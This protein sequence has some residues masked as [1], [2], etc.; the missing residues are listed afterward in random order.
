[1]VQCTF[2]STSGNSLLFSQSSADIVASTENRVFCCCSLKCLNQYIDSLSLV[3]SVCH[4]LRTRPL[5]STPD[6]ITFGQSHNNSQWDS[7][8]ATIGKRDVL[9]L[10]H[11]GGAQPSQKTLPASSSSSEQLSHTQAAPLF[12][13]THQTHHWTVWDVNSPRAIAVLPTGDAAVIGPVRAASA[14]LTLLGPVLHHFPLV[15][16]MVEAVVHRL[17]QQEQ[18]SNDTTVD[19]HDHHGRLQG[20]QRKAEDTSGRTGWLRL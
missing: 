5:T 9:L 16:G 4:C 18:G 17:Q 2:K 14:A 12:C 10:V 6:D 8:Q 15:Q 3:L 20:L 13:T 11:H 7:T 1:M 19:S